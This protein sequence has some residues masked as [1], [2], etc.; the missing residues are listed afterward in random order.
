MAAQRIDDGVSAQVRAAYDALARSYDRRWSRYID[1]SLAK[2]IGALALKGNE[3]ILDV[4]CGT[5]ELERRLFAR[6][7][8]L[9]VTGVDLSPKM[10]AEAEAKHVAGDVRW[11]EGQAAHLPVADGQFDVVVCANSFHYFREP[12]DSLCEFRRALTREGKLVLADWCDDYLMC[13]LCSVWLRLTDPAFFCTATL[14]ACQSMLR[15]AGFDVLHSERFKASWLWGMMLLVASPLS[16][17]DDW[18]ARHDRH[19]AADSDQRPRRPREPAT[20]PAEP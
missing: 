19:R 1:V 2:V 20:G 9:H 17:P 8:G 16:M 4:A 15:Q 12:L 6:W 10:L 3:R 14:S 11:L 7:P 18:E 5:G 13:R